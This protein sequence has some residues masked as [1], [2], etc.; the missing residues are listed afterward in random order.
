MYENSVRIDHI[1]AQLGHIKE[2]FLVVINDL[3]V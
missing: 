3:F 1:D 2:K